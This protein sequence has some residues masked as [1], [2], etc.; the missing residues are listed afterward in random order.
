[1]GSQIV[2]LPWL[3][4]GELHLSA[5]QVGWVQ[6]AVL[7]PGVV[8]MLVGGALADRRGAMTFLPWLYATVM[9]C[10]VCMLWLVAREA[11]MLPVLLLYALTLGVCQAFIQPLRDKVL[12]RFMGT[13]GSLQSS[14]VQVSLCVYIAQ[15]L[16]VAIAGQ[17]SRL[18]VAG[19]LAIQASA[20]LVCAGVFWQLLRVSPPAT[21]PADNEAV[22]GESVGNAIGSG[23]G[24]VMRHRVLRHLILL[25]GFNGF[26][27]I[28]VFVVAL[29]L[30]ARDIYQQDALYFS[31]LQ[32]LFVVGN[33]TATLALLK[34]GQVEYPGRSVLFCLLYAGIIMVAIGAK[35]TSTGLF[36]LVFA[37]GVVAGIS[38]S[39][40]KSLLQQ[41]VEERFRGRALSIYQ[42]A[43]FGAAPLGALACGYAMHYWGALML[44]KVGGGMSLVLFGL[45]LCSR[46]MWKST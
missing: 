38:S 26:M 40:G 32:L 13:S 1:M 44:F 18:G 42:L 20:L 39:L 16:G 29:P 23:F 36:M 33:V 43:L 27:H 22:A 9:L 35:P 30:L 8:L 24:F 19:V 21:Q 7:L 4:V 41:Q 2:L 5:S 15:A 3:A 17:L 6:S 45:Y 12:P 14:V 10:H 25:V 34:R 28:G 46:S 37:W 31:S 11:L